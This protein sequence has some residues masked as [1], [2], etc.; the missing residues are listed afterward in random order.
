MRASQARPVYKAFANHV[1]GRASLAN[2][3][4]LLKETG[5][6]LHGLAVCGAYAMAPMMALAQSLE[7]LFVEFHVHLVL[8]QERGCV[9]SMYSTP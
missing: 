2:V 5:G 4:C 1:I 6:I 3:E 9:R 8:P 7:L